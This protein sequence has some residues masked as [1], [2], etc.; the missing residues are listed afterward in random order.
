[1]IIIDGEPKIAD[2]DL[3]DRAWEAN[4]RPRIDQPPAAPLQGASATAKPIAD[5][6]PDYLE[7]RARRESAAARRDA[8]QADLAELDVA[9]R[10]GEFVPVAEAR[11]RDLQLRAR[12]RRRVPGLRN[13]RA[14]RAPPGSRARRARRGT[15][16]AARMTLPCW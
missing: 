3:A 6:V 5:D 14:G 1:V 12:R 13:R 15:G 16:N 10:K 11:R 4:T 7:S 2:P 8:A 9:Q